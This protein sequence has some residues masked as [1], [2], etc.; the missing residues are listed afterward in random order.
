[1]KKGILTV[2]P[3]INSSRNM[4]SNEYLYELGISENNSTELVFFF[5]L[6]LWV[7]LVQCFVVYEIDIFYPQHRNQWPRRNIVEQLNKHNERVYV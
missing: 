2:T 7:L 3:L 4:F 6:F 5:P 1:M